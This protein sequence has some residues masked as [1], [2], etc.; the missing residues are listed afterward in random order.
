MSEPPTLTMEMDL[1]DLSMNKS[2][3]CKRKPQ[4]LQT[5]KCLNFRTGT[6]INI[7]GT[8]RLADPAFAELVVNFDTVP[9]KQSVRENGQYSTT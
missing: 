6:Y 8:A 3:N 4:Y 5:V 9:G 2:T 7:N 1:C